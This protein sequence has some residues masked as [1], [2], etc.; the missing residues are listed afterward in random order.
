MKY[1]V[2]MMQTHTKR[3]NNLTQELE[4]V[5]AYL[6]DCMGSDSYTTVDGRL[7]RDHAITEAHSI[8]A[9]RGRPAFFVIKAS[10]FHNFLDLRDS[11][12]GK[13]IRTVTR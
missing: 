12:K 10:S 11:G 3:W 13:F 1:F 8:A 6:I 4:T 7:S 2:G 5:P 9:K